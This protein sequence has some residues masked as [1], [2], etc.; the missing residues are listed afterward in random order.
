[1]NDKPVTNELRA[2]GFGYDIM[3][4]LLA[5]REEEVTARLQTLNFDDRSLKIAECQQILDLL[6]S[7]GVKLEKCSTC[8]RVG[9]TGDAV[10]SLALGSAC[11]WCDNL[12]CEECEKIEHGVI[13]KDCI[14]DWCPNC[15]EDSDEC[16]GMRRCHICISPTCVADICSRCWLISIQTA[17]EFVERFEA[18]SLDT[19]EKIRNVRRRLGLGEM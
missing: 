11:A 6:T 3:G 5:Y 12:E 9:L 10:D 19:Q 15:G 17:P 1:M 8:P 2:R 16:P 14:V 4:L 18:M 13:C 7:R